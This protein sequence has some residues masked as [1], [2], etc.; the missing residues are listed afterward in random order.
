MKKNYLDKPKSWTLGLLLLASAARVAEAATIVLDFEGVGDLAAVNDFYN[1][2]TDSA[3][4]SGTNFGISFSDNSLGLI[5]S[6]AGGFGNFANEPSP[7]TILFFLS[8][9]HPATMNV[10]A[11]FHTSFSFY[12]TSVNDPGN[13]TV[14]DGLDGTGNIL[15][16]LN[17]PALGG[18]CSGD[19]HGA[20]CNWMEVG[21]TFTGIARSVDFGGAADHIGFDN[22]TLGSLVPVPIPAAAWL[23]GSALAGLFSLTHRWKV[24]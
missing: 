2:G 22:I 21:V 6:D 9:D 17:L 11:G 19:P 8:S 10:A 24:R 12:Y 4:N 3:G 13:V 20:N 14:Y 7:D 15:A 5:D 23:L 16:I 1:G 18:I